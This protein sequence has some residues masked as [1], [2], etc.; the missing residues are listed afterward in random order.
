MQVM[1]DRGHHGGVHVRSLRDAEHGAL[2]VVG[3]HGVAEHLRERAVGPGQLHKVAILVLAA[4][5]VLSLRSRGARRRLGT[6]SPLLE[7]A[8]GVLVAQGLHEAEEGALPRVQGEGPHFAHVHAQGPVHARALN[9]NHHPPV[10]HSPVWRLCAAISTNVVRRV[11]GAQLGEG[12]GG[13]VPGFAPHARVELGRVGGHAL[14]RVQAVEGELDSPAQRL[15]PRGEICVRLSLQR[16]S[17]LRGHHLKAKA[18]ARLGRVLVLD[19]AEQEVDA[20]PPR[21]GSLG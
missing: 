17:A 6:Q 21:L 12:R 1:V 20:T 13:H 16:E 10:E 14:V 19:G 3:A 4:N 8:V 7:H 18:A 2:R 11:R 15:H 9:A 5:P